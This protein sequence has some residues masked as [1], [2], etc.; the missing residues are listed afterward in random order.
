MKIFIILL[1]T[2]FGFSYLCSKPLKVNEKKE[3]DYQKMR[4]NLRNLDLRLD[5]LLNSIDSDDSK[6]SID[7]DENSEDNSIIKKTFSES[8]IPL[9]FQ[10]QNGWDLFVLRELALKHSPE[11]LIKKA[12]SDEIEKEISVTKFGY[13]PTANAKVSYN[14]YAKISQFETYSEPEPYKTFSYGVDGR[15]VLYNGFKTRKQIETTNLELSRS[16]ISLLFEEQSILK[17]LTNH[18]FTA[19]SSQVKLEYLPKIEAVI[20]ERLSVYKKQLSSGVVDSLLVNNAVRDLEN[21]RS[22]SL[23]SKLSMELAK[24][25]MNLL[26]DTEEKFWSNHNY[27]ITPKDF[28]WV[29]NF[30]IED[31]VSE[32]LGQAGIDIAKSKLKVI[33]TEGSPVLELIASTGHNSRNRLEFD[34][35][36]HEI[37]FGLNLTMPISG[38]FLTRRKVEKAKQEINKSVLLKNKLTKQQRNQFETE[39]FKLEQSEKTLKLQEELWKLQKERLDKIMS[40]FTKRISEKSVIL[41]EKETLLRREMILELSKISYI[42]Q[43]YILDL[44]N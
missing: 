44:I 27:F 5:S 19:L 23:D 2:T 14:D 9:N 22:Q 38:R 40:M 11:L 12:E 4:E 41:M 30:N 33:E 15:W 16:Q 32:K 31:S 10:N 28:K 1:F 24:A 21:M 35:T 43:K 8:F 42:K 18:F 17:K 37:T 39:N 3:I 26:L 13:Y 34:S 20:E 29:S 6:K 25:E 36:G 7:E